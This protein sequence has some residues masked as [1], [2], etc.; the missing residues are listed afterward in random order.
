MKH[1][2]ATERFK[3]EAAVYD[4]KAKD[5][6][7]HINTM[8]LIIDPNVFPFP[9]RDHVDFINYALTCLGNVDGKTFLHCGCGT[10]AST[11]YFAKRGAKITGIDISKENI[12][13]CKM[14]AKINEIDDH[15]EFISSPV[16]LLDYE[17]QYF[18]L[19]F[20]NQ[21]LHHLDLK[22]ACMNFAA[23]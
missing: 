20:G 23:C 1:W 5:F 4:N 22:M 12:R 11:V 19:I 14:R 18:D 9:N 2:N 13:I 16:E 21:I 7:R 17:D 15:I 6:L 8:D 3:I 10:G